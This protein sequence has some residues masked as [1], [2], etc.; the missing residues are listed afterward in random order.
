MAGLQSVCECHQGGSSHTQPQLHGFIVSCRVCVACVCACAG[1]LIMCSDDVLK[2]QFPCDSAGKCLFILNET[3][4]SVTNS[5]CDLSAGFVS[6]FPAV[7]LDS[8]SE[9]AHVIVFFT[10]GVSVVEL[11]SLV[12]CK[13]ALRALTSWLSDWS[14]LRFAVVCSNVLSL[15]NSWTRPEWS[16]ERRVFLSTLRQPE[17][18][19][20][21][22][23][24]EIMACYCNHWYTSI[25]TYYWSLV[26]PCLH[27]CTLLY[28][29]N[30]HMH[31]LSCRIREAFV[32]QSFDFTSLSH[33]SVFRLVKCSSYTQT[34]VSA[35]SAGHIWI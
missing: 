29:Y 14:Q 26:W 33:K 17:E 22:S 27:L 31:T 35:Q 24:S 30:K 21:V 15:T 9:N 23:D 28:I 5:S 8:W 13:P 6:S 32:S 16:Q 1:R 2:L 19:R 3:W 34:G 18:T 12:P 11:R 7:S 25:M 20:G 10:C 4:S